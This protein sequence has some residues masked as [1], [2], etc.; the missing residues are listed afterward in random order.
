ML[1]QSCER[2][3]P[4]VEIINKRFSF[5]LQCTIVIVASTVMTKS[6]TYTSSVCGAYNQQLTV[7]QYPHTIET[8]TFDNAIAKALILNL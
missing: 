8:T 6:V 1:L 5:C 2:A 4:Q 3:K 7:S